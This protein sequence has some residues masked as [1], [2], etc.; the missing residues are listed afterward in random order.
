[1]TL[2]ASTG[3][4]VM[5]QGYKAR[6]WAQAIGVN[7]GFV[8]DGSNPDQITFSGNDAITLGFAPGMKVSIKGST[9][10]DTTL[11]SE[12][13]ISS[14][15]TDGSIAYVTTGSMAAT[16]TALA[17]TAITACKGG[18]LWD[19]FR[20]GQLVLFSGAL[21]TNADA[22]LSTGNIILTMTDNA[23]AVT[24]GSYA[25]GLLLEDNPT[26]A[27]IEKLATQTWKGLATGSGTLT[28]FRFIGNPTDA[29]G[30][31]TTLPRYQG[32]VGT[33]GSG[34]DLV[35]DNPTIVSGQYYTLTSFKLTRREYYGATS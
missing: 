7:Y 5:Q 6:V 4:R 30:L 3:L 35:I 20:H 13:E 2:K 9:S 27:E 17:G 19:I 26:A 28:G 1:M 34:A 24:G 15:A 10:N 31:S 18:S 25:N 29:H 22:A 16:E 23:G 8:D 12:P 14:I 11:D 21:P 33:S 32:S